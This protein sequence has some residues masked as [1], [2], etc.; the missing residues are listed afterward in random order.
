MKTLLVGNWKMNLGP[1]AARGL[2]QKVR[3]LATNLVHTEVWVTPPMVSLPAVAQEL[4]GSAVK[5]GAQNVHWAAQGAFTG[6][7]SVPMLRELS[8]SYALT[9]HSERRMH[10]AESADLVA[11]RTLGA[12]KSGITVV[13]CVGE[14][15]A[16]RERGD[17]KQVLRAQLAPLFTAEF[18]PEISPNLVLAYEP[19]WAIG[20]GKVA[21]P[22][23]IAETTGELFE[24]WKQL[25]SHPLPPLLYGGSV[26]PTN[27]EAIL[28]VDGVCGCLIGGASI[29]PEKLQ[30]MIQISEARR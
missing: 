10:F 14:T 12:L 13:F 20:T 5:L 28:N 16:E 3:A 11:K 24:L 30:A 27:C 29:V 8:C 6:E 2:A 17:T 23:Q 4:H 15:L 18:T 21:T 7:V 22:D 9:G 1:E 26:D 25:T 19:V